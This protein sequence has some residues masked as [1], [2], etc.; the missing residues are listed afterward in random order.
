MKKSMINTQDSKN[1]LVPTDF[2]SVAET[3][4]NHACYLARIFNKQ[5]TLLHVVESNLFSSEK[6]MEEQEAKDL[7]HLNEVAN[8][9][10]AADHVEIV[11]LTRRGNIFDTIGEVAEEINASLVIMG[12]HGV[13]GIQRVIGSRALRVITNSNRP[14]VIVQEKRIRE[15]GYKNIV[16]PIDFSR[17]T[18][19]K[20]AWA[21]ELA[22]KFDS[23]FHILADHESDEFASRALN[24]NIHYA[25]NYLRERN[26]KFTVKKIDKGESFAKETV[27]YAAGLDADLIII[28]TDPELDLGNYIA[29]PDEQKIIGNDAQIPVMAINEVDHMQ[30]KRAAMF[31]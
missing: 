10:K 21:A 25:E 5:I 29:G 17:E 14:F 3:A 7:A 22:G 23:T 8:R 12:T 15:H 24:N 1:I 13:R 30:L 4:I 26:C 11:C 27:R 20:L 18:K 31:Q 19:Q 2:S 16:L 9:V 28:M 6:K